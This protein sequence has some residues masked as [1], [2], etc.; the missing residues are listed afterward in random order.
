M[1][2]TYYWKHYV[3]NNDNN[4]PYL[5]YIKVFHRL[6]RLVESFEKSKKLIDFWLGKIPQKM[7]QMFRHSQANCNNRPKCV[8]CLGFHYYK[9]YNNKKSVSTT[10]CDNCKGIH[11]AIY[12]NC[13]T[14]LDNQLRT[15]T[16]PHPEKNRNDSW[17]HRYK[18][19]TI[20]TNNTR[21]NIQRFCSFRNRNVI[22]N[23]NNMIHLCT[24]S[25]CS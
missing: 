17:N 6:F 9:Y 15:Q 22:W 19:T 18:E 24:I 1:N 8:K 10:D 3:D 4:K 13:P 14:L 11:A 21:A 7:I 23:V 16:R 20:L 5:N 25:L 2:S 12:R